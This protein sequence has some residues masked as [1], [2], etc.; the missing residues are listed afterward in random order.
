V[1][2]EADDTDIMKINIRIRKLEKFIGVS[3]LN[4]GILE[5]LN[6]L[7]FLKKV[8]VIFTEIS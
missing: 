2:G 6:F 5:E 3:F 8:L 7:K 4:K 1:S